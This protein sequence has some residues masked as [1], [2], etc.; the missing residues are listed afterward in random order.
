MFLILSNFTEIWGFVNSVPGILVF[1]YVIIDGLFKY[2]KYVNDTKR[3]KE[4]EKSLI[5]LT[6]LGAKV[7]AM[8]EDIENDNLSSTSSK[9]EMLERIDAIKDQINVVL[10]NYQSEQR[11]RLEMEKRIDMLDRHVISGNGSPSVLT[12]LAVIEKD[13][14][15]LEKVIIQLENKK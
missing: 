7:E 2:I 8:K 4:I 11:V 15:D 12:R 14:K 5:E 13:I 3:G 1:L 9:R 6:L 10:A